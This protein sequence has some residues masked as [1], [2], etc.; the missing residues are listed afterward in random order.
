MW[1][2]IPLVNDPDTSDTPVPRTA[3]H[4]KVYHVPISIL[5]GMAERKLIR[6]RSHE[7]QLPKFRRVLSSHSKHRREHA[8]FVSTSQMIRIQAIVHKL[9]DVNDGASTTGE[10]HQ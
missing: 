9:P 5:I 2:E 4:V 7:E 8:C 10:S 1:H 3:R 6:L